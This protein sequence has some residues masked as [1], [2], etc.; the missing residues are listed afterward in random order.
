MT[1]N[2][3]DQLDALTINCLAKKMHR[4]LSIVIEDTNLMLP[5]FF[6]YL[7]NYIGTIPLVNSAN[8]T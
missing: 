1:S 4:N 7:M 2:H 5:G 8:I 3:F 6:K